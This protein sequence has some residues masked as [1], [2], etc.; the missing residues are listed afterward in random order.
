M[1][2]RATLALAALALAAVLA[3]QALAARADLELTRLV[4]N[5]TPLTAQQ[6]ARADMLVGRADRLSLDTRTD[7]ER[8]TLRARAGDFRGAGA[9][10]E[11]V[12]R[13]EPQNLEAWA[14]LARAAERYDPARAA[15]A[16]AR[17]RRLAPPVR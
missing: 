8:A 13:R 10:F 15:E 2:A 17:T 11:S 7:I 3:V 5:P 16:R 4:L 9:K 12:V 1:L 14:L 6:Q